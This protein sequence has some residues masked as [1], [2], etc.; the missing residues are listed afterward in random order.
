MEWRVNCQVVVERDGWL[1]SHGTPTFT[2]NPAYVGTD[3]ATVRKVV[4][5]IVDPARIAKEIHVSAV[6]V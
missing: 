5:D 2:L 6:L 1:C 4:C 3:I